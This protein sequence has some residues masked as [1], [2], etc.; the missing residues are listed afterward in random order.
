MK[1]AELKARLGNA[2]LIPTLTIEDLDDAIPLAEAL[3]AGGI[4]VIEVTLRTPNALAAIEKIATNVKNVK[5]GI[6]TVLNAEQFKQAIDVGSEFVVSPGTLE[7][8]YLTAKQYDTAFIPGVI[9]PSEVMQAIAYGCDFL[10]YFPAEAMASKKIL[11]AYSAV[12][13]DV[14]FC[15]TGGISMGN[16]TEYL[17]LKNVH[18]VGGG[19]LTPKTALAN[20]DWSTITALAKQSLQ[21][22]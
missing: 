13:P 8:H 19:W 18:C 14:T 22:F 1:L 10:K 2:P 16:A 12:F 21:S 15:P 4:Q 5:V 11:Q 6:G 7:Q 17:T 3:A 9:T 20:K